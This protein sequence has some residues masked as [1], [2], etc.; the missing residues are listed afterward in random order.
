MRNLFKNIIIFLSALILTGIIIY[1]TAFMIGVNEANKAYG[2]E[3]S[4]KK[5]EQKRSKEEIEKRK[6][7]LNILANTGKCIKCDLTTRQSDTDNEDLYKAIQSAKNKNLVIDLSGSDLSFVQL[8]KID[9]SNA[10]LSKMNL[11][12]TNLQEANLSNTNLSGSNL[13]ITNLSG[14]NLQGANLTEVILDRTQLPEAN[15]SNAILHKAV[16][17]SP[18]LREANLTKINLTG[19][20]IYNFSGTITMETKF[21]DADFRGAKILGHFAKNADLTGVRFD[22]FLIR[23][24]HSFSLWLIKFWKDIKSSGYYWKIRKLEKEKN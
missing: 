11:T 13:T 9:L 21:I 2:T 24:L 14:T 23:S 22:G 12:G 5:Y 7:D 18:N 20:W 4:M 8:N 16:L 3:G 17:I 10:D 19:A 6:N 15:L 1:I